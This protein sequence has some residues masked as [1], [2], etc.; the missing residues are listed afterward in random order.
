M[1]RPARA[2]KQRN[3]YIVD[4]LGKAGLE[5]ELSVANVRHCMNPDEV[6]SLWIEEYGLVSGDTDVT[7]VNPKFTDKV[8]TDI[9]MGK[10][11]ARLVN[12]F[13]PDGDFVSAAQRVYSSPM[14]DIVD[15]YNTG[16]Y[17]EPSYVQTRAFAT[18]EF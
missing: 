13:A 4:A 16:A 11:Y 2:L 15:N 10:V 5:R 7:E 9:Q 18:G 14:C 1:K 12:S 8:P 17:Y 3:R 6:V